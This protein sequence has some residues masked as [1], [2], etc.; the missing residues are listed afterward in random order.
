MGHISGTSN[1]RIRWLPDEDG[2]ARITRAW[3]C[4]EKAALPDR[5]DGRPVTALARHALA[6]DEREE[7]G[8]A[9]EIRSGR[10]SAGAEWNNRHLRELTLPPCL[11]TIGDY[12]FLNCAALL[13]LTLSDSVTR[14]GGAVFMNCRALHDITLLREGE[15]GVSLAYLCDELPRELDVLILGPGEHRARLLFPEYQELYEENGPAHHFDYQIEGAGYPYHHVFV[16]K[17]L[18]YR[19]Y[20]AL[21]RV[22]RGMEGNEETAV[23]L[24]WY[25]LRYPEELGAQARESYLA[26]L[27]PRT[28][29]LLTR[30][31][32][33]GQAADIHALAAL[34]PLEEADLAAACD[35]ARAGGRTEALALL[36]ELR[37]RGAPKSRIKRYEL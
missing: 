2:G 13:K 10:A 28:G 14:W 33:A 17:R 6:A 22:Y 29:A 34:V 18:T 9:L 27:K 21:F 11:E 24:A 8:E 23:T 30:L 35:A 25:R 20:D 1:W 5:I 16:R 7:P 12:C 3:T 15:Q 26:Y 31:A 4:D 19:D 36:L 37:H 32:D